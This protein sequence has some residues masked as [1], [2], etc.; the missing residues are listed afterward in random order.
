MDQG[1]PTRTIGLCPVPFCGRE[2]RYPGSEYCAK[3]GDQARN[4]WMFL[5]QR[6]VVCS[7]PLESRSRAWA[8]PGACKDLRNN[9]WRFNLTAAEYRAIYYGQDGKCAGCQRSFPLYS[10]AT[11]NRLYI[12]HCHK[13]QEI[14]GLLC[15]ECN[16]AVGKMQ[17][18]P[19]VAHRLAEYLA[20]DRPGYV[21]AS[22]RSSPHYADHPVHRRWRR[23]ERG[24]STIGVWS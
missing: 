3:H 19:E 24:Q 13:T 20:H 5:P 1:T 2:T 7:R 17:D 15:G 16:L 8:C 9:L 4:G 6:C 12:D 23:V 18:D 22:K 10:E 21:P 14:R 11:R